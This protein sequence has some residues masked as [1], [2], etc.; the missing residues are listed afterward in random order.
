MKNDVSG[1]EA[2]GSSAGAIS[3]SIGGI[4]S[5][6]GSAT[7]GSADTAGAELVDVLQVAEAGDMDSIAPGSLQNRGALGGLAGNTVDG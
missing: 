3:S 5:S 1:K 2:S 7:A 4:S 6:T